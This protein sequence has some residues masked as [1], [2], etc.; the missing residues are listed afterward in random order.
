MCALQPVRGHLPGARLPAQIL[1]GPAPP[2]HTPSTPG[3][4]AHRTPA[5]LRAEPGD[6]D[7]IPAR[8]AR[9]RPE[10]PHPSGTTARSAGSTAAPPHTRRPTTP[11]VSPGH[12]P[13]GPPHPAADPP[14][15]PGQIQTGHHV[16]HKPHQ[17]ISRQPLP[18]IRRHQKPL[19]PIHQTKP[20]RYTADPQP[21]Q[22]Q[23][24]EARGDFAT[25]SGARGTRTRRQPR[26]PPDPSLS[27]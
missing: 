14:R 23:P 16:Q 20:L 19:I 9:A 18:H 3:R 4:T 15:R 21:H 17:M 5:L 10:T 27:T 1:I 13:P 6:R 26:R 22:D 8:P 24:A 25:G 7:V 2:G 12:T 11:A